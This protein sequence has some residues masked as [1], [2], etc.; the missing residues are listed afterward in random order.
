MRIWN[1]VAVSA[2]ALLGACAPTYVAKPYS[3]GAQRVQKIAIADDS[4]PESIFAPEA[5]SVGSNFGLIGA[6]IDAG[7][8][9]S[10][11]AALAGALNSVS[12]NAEDTLERSLVEA[13]ARQGIQA[14]V[15]TGSQ[16]EKRV[17]LANYSKTAGE[18]DAHLDIVLSHFGYLSAGAGQPWRPTADATVRLVS[19]ADGRVLLENRIAY[20]VL[21]APRG[22]I[23]LS[24]NPEFAFRNREEMVNNPERLANGLKDAMQRIASTTATLIQ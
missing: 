1:V 21:A 8:Q 6:L 3:A 20:N 17:F 23:T 5:A 18:V 19:A 15:A 10:R 11:Q 16:R 9:S 12:F 13:L 24:P 14:N 7:V 4:V 22:V 2:T